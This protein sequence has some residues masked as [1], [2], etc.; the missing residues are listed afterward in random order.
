M[1]S[2]RAP[3]S[4]LVTPLPPVHL[5]LRLSLHHRFS[6]R[7]SY[8]SCLAGCRVTSHHTATSH[9]PVPPPLIVPLSRFL[10]GWLSRRLSSHRRLLSTCASTS[11]RTAASHPTPLTPFVWLV[12]ESLLVMLPSPVCLCLHLSSCPSRASCPA[13]CRV[14]SCHAT[15]A[16]C[17]LCLRLSLCRRLSS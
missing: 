15:T 9:P 13:G 14:T 5:R 3:A 12:V 7:P 1:A 17:C 10:S 6:P 2:H 16:S 8:A 11:H 4:P